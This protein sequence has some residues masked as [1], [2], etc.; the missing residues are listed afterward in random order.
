MTVEEY[1]VDSEIEQF[2][3]EHIESISDELREISLDVS[4]TRLLFV[5][6]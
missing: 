3:D 4:L 2:I 5:M 1:K 6:Y